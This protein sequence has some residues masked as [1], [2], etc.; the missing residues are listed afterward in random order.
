[1]LK[2]Q[3]R[4]MFFMRRLMNKPGKKQS[5]DLNDFHE[6]AYIKSMKRYQIETRG[7][8]PDSQQV[9]DIRNRLFSEMRNDKWQ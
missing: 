1:M 3:N 5:N 8:L 4:G 2:V 6:A 7:M 9:R